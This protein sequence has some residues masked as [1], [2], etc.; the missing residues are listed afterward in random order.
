MEVITKQQIVDDVPRR[1]EAQYRHWDDVR[2]QD[3]LTQLKALEKPIDASA[4]NTIIGKDSWTQ[5]KCDECG[6]SVELVVQLGQEPDYE[7]ATACIC[8]KCLKAAVKLA[9]GF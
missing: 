2:K 5:V 4:V 9:K 1:W 6:Q 3:I 8:V 7:S